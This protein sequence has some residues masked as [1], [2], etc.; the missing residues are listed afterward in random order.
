VVQIQEQTNEPNNQKQTK[1]LYNQIIEQNNYIKEN[2][3]TTPALKF[4]D[5]KRQAGK[6]RKQ[7]G[8]EEIVISTNLF[9]KYPEKVENILKHKIGHAITHQKYIN[10]QSH[11]FRWKKVMR[12]IGQK[13]ERTHSLQLAD[14]NY[15]IECK[16]CGFS[17]G[18]YRKSKIVKHPE[19]ARC[20][21]CG[22]N[23]KSREAA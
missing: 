11:G 8:R 17:D 15:I 22:G 4:S 7:A 19:K 10:P 20:P 23:V 16:D 21:K 14:F 13:P 3:E 6:Y 12:K 2:L 18:R 5:M 1:K 9:E